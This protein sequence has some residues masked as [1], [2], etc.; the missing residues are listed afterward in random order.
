MRHEGKVLWYD[1]KLGRGQIVDAR[2]IQYS[3]VKAELV[4]SRELTTTMEVIFDSKFSVKGSLKA[5]QVIVFK[6]AK[7]V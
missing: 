2:G 1:N 5:T 3:V 4:N 6:V 7:G